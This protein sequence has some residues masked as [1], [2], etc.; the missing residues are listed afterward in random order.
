MEPTTITIAIG[1]REV[2]YNLVETDAPPA[3]DYGY[4]IVLYEGQDN[5]RFILVPS[6]SMA[7]QEGRNR[8]GMYTFEA[9]NLLDTAAIAQLL[10]EHMRR[11]KYNWK[12]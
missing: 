11:Y 4:V 3:F 6:E 10:W 7:H 12:E 8:S 5:Q 9:I 1:G 2:T